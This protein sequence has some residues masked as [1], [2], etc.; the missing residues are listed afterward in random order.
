[1]A[2]V[3]VI[4]AG[5]AGLAAAHALRQFDVTVIDGADRV[6]GKLRT[7]AIGG[8]D[9]DEGAES[10]LARVPE[11]LGLARAVG[12]G[13]SIV[14]PATTSASVWARGRLRP[15]PSRTVFGVPASVRS[16]QGV[17]SPAETVRAAL[18]LLLPGQDEDDGDVSVGALVGRRMGRAV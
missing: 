1:M 3:V 7:S 13:D 18:D 5:I 16:L 8:F 9:V 14:H 12:R 15:L 4:G 11:G 6:G 17:L 10:F 2:H